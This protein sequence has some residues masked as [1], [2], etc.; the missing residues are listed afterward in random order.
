[1]L[2]R[3][4]A[5]VVLVGDEALRG[6]TLQEIGALGDREAITEAERAGVLRGRL[7]MSGELRCALGRRDCVAQDGVGIAGL[8]SM[9]GEPS[10][11]EGAARRLG[12]RRERAAVEVDLAVERDRVLDREACKLVTE[13]HTGR[14]G[15][16]HS[17][18]ETLV[19]SSDAFPCE[20]HQ[21]P[22]LRLLRHDRNGVEWRPR[23]GAPGGRLGRAPRP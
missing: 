8:L 18:R 14:L 16:E 11:I 1:V 9:M 10:E 19:Q 17:R 7:A 2:E 20:L 6:S 4:D 21:Q 13:R 15:G 5:V 12:E 22:E 23:L 3:R